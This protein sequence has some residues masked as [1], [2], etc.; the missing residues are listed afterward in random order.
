MSIELSVNTAS[1]VPLYVQVKNQIRL[2]IERRQLSPGEQLPTV[3][4]LALNLGINANTV[5]RVYADLEREGYLSRKRG[6]GTFA[7]D[8]HEGAAPEPPGKGRLAETVRQLIALGYSP[9][10]I[11]EMTAEVLGEGD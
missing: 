6:V 1:E 3:R 7:V 8:P 11:I 5:A 10:Q 2:A 9:R 4:D